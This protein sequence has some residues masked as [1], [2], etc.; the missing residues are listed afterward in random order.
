MKLRLFLSFLF[1]AVLITAAMPVIAQKTVLVDHE[2][3][4]LSDGEFVDIRM[5]NY[6]W[7]DQTIRT[8]LPDGTIQLRTQKIAQEGMSSPKFRVKTVKGKDIDLS[9]T[10]GKVIVLNFWF[11]GCPACMDER[12]KLNELKAKF[13]DREDVIF[14]ALTYDNEKTVKNYLAKNPIDY[15]V[16]SD[17]DA[18]L[19]L[20]AFSGY[21]KNVVISR[22]GEI[23]YWR[24][25]VRAWN[26][27]ESV[28]SGEIAK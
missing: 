8:V 22:S 4:P 10:T 11:V 19:K 3:N 21:P 23:V 28:I 25:T 27:F 12:P 5:A 16:V 15:D 7:T 2:G 20:F 24:S 18:T 17:A 13:H 6:Q 14:L 1:L 9:K 26:K